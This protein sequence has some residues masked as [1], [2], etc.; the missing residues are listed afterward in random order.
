MEG[1][2]NCNGDGNGGTTD[3]DQLSE[4]LKAVEGLEAE[5]ATTREDMKENKIS[6]DAAISNAVST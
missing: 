1:G 3:K 4:L 5:I 6:T 2:G